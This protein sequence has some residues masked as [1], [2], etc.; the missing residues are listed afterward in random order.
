MSP[1][2]PAE[3]AWYVTG[4]FY[5]AEKS[6]AIADYGYFLHLGG[7]AAP[8]FAAAPA[9]SSAHFTF[10]AEPFQAARLSNGGLQLGL[11][12]AGSFSVF[13]QRRPAGDFDDPASFARGEC[14]GRFRRTSLVVGTTVTGAAGQALITSNVFSARLTEST[15]FEFG[16]QRYDLA[17]MLGAGV[18]QFGTADGQAIMPAPAGYALVLPFTGSAL[19]LGRDGG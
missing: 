11:D 2:L 4:R 1:L 6:G 16:G 10:A 8:L 17:R 7:I 19:A 12:P 15:P 18:T 5:A 13:L 3:L 14:I 9:E